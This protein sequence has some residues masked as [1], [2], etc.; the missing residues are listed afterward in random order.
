MRHGGDSWNLLVGD[1]GG[2]KGRNGGKGRWKMLMM[3]DVGRLMLRLEEQAAHLTSM[4]LG[5]MGR[6][7]VKRGRWW[8]GT[9]SDQA[10]NLAPAEATVGDAGVVEPR[11]RHAS[12]DCWCV[13][14][15]QKM[16]QPL[17]AAWGKG[18]RRD[19]KC[20]SGPKF[21]GSKLWTHSTNN[22]SLVSTGQV[23]SGKQ[24]IG[25]SMMA[26]DAASSR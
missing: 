3:S 20:F 25:R 26:A 13:S 15:H 17:Q 2:G 24:Q 12:R 7:Y 22:S 6:H 4:V 16:Q 8:V 18:T 23:S 10:S 21:A 9:K 1:G 5:G 11:Q 19:G 14:G